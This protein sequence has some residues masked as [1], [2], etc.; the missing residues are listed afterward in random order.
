MREIPPIRTLRKRETQTQFDQY[1]VEIYP[2][3]LTSILQ[4]TYHAGDV[5]PIWDQNVAREQCSVRAQ[6]REACPPRRREAILR[7]ARGSLFGLL[8]A[9]GDDS[10]SRINGGAI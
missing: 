6:K 3:I 2:T 4:P 7:P 10:P 8:R 1:R 5:V 9:H